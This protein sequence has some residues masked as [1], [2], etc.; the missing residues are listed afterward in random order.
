MYQPEM[1]TGNITV[2]ALKILTEQS[3]GSFENLPD[4]KSTR[5]NFSRLKNCNNFVSSVKRYVNS[6]Q[7]CSK[8]IIRRDNGRV[9]LF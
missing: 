6:V 2:I 5:I 8:H 1:S 4:G 9:C 7:Q 3:N